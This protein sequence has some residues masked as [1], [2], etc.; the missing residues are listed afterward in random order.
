MEKLSENP[1]P[2][3]CKKLRGQYGYRVRAGNYR[4]I[5]DIIDSNLIIKV[6]AIGNRKDIYR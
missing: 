1:R 4:I 2:A 3:G 5:Y 6:L